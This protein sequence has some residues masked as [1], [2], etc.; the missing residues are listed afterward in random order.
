MNRS[1]RAATTETERREAADAATWREVLRTLTGSK[2]GR[3]GQRDLD[4]AFRALA[5][6]DPSPHIPSTQTPT[7]RESQNAE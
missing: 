4:E 2:P 7:G 1:G 3:T 6:G 5:A